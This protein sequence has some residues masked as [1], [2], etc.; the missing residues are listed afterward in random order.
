MQVASVED[1]RA[2][3]VFSP[4]ASALAE[5]G[6]ISKKNNTSDYRLSEQI[7]RAEAIKMALG[8]A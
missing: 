8:I 3:E 6:I 7:T 5:A 4:Y 1:I 2:S